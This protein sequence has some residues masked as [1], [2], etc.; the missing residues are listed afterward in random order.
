M[1]SKRADLSATDAECTLHTRLLQAA[2]GHVRS[3]RVSSLDLAY[4]FLFD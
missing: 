1:L 3:A 4:T 2:A